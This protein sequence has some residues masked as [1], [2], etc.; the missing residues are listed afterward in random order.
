[1]TGFVNKINYAGI[2]FAKTSHDKKC[3]LIINRMSII[4]SILMFTFACFALLFK[5]Y[6]LLYF[7]TPFLFAFSLAPW[8]NSKGWLTFSKFFFCFVPM[9]CLIII[10]IF[11]SI[12]QGDRFFFL[13]TATIPILLFR[14]TWLV[15]SVFYLNVA[16]FVFAQWY[17]SNHAPILT[18]PKEIEIIYWYFTLISVFAVLFFVIRYFKGDSEIYEKEL[19]EKNDLI[20]EKNKEITDSIK[21]AKR[22]QQAQMPSEKNFGIH[23]RRLKNKT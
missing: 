17:Q 16:A 19:E 23:L 20:S 18:I 3:I 2:D 10:C 11:N 7:T 9:T 14:K 4:L 6:M 13:T 1:M 5:I 21:Y 8:F 15:Y 12:E 22:I